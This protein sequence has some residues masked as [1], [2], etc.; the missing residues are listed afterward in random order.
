MFIRIKKS[1]N[2][3]RKTIQIVASIRKGEK[4]IQK[5]VRYIGV[6]NDDKELELMM[7]LAENIK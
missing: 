6:A 5:T 7:Q 2:S 1:K 3:P 4:I